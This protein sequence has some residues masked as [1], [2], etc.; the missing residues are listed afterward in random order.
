MKKDLIKF[1]LEQNQRIIF[2]LDKKNKSTK[3]K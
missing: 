3:I 1:I 2:K